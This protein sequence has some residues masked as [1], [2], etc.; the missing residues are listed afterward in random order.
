MYSQESILQLENRIGFGDLSE[1]SVEINPQ[2][3]TG[4]SGMTLPYFHRLANLDNLFA[5]VSKAQTSEANFNAYLSQLKTDAV[6]SVVVAIMDKNKAYQD[7]VDYSDTLI[8]RPELFD[9]AI[10][11]ALAISAIEQ[12]VSTS[13]INIEERNASLKYDK[14]KIEL[15][16]IRDEKGNILAKGIRASLYRSIKIATNIIFP[17]PIIVEALTKYW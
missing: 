4:T 1:P 6:K 15:D 8:T 5:T 16:G 17:K 11:Y 12:M 14:L 10:G 3:V 13:R 7:D 2:H 9:D